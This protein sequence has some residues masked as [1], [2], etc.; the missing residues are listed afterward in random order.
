[1]LGTPASPY[2]QRWSDGRHSWRHVAEGGF[3]ASRFEITTIPEATARA[4]TIRHHYAASFPAARFTYGLVT[5][6]ETLRIDGTM[7][8]GKALVGVAV[9]SVPMHA[10]VLTNVFPDLEPFTESLELGRFVLTDTPANAESWFLGRL[11]RRAASDGI[12]G[13]VSFADPLPRHRTVTDIDD[14]GQVATRLEQVTPGHCGVIYQAANA[15]SLGR[16]T[17][18]TLTYVPRAG[19]V[20]S[21]RTLSKIRGQER[22]SDAA[23]RHLVDLGATPRGPRADPS[24]WLRD[25]L[26]EIG[27]RS[28][29]HPGNYR[30]AWT[31][32][33]GAARRRD[34]VLLP[35]TPYPKPETG[36]VRV[37]AR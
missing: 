33:P 29:R 28:V 11:F 7:I 30:Y 1:M 20:L 18:R 25:A 6:D 26:D 17:A 37:G 24:A 3:D 14:A 13:I 34:R 8:D 31:I 35:R 15:L 19:L 32:G 16:S 23:E 12:R 36:R 27:A 9:L 10:R 4:F 21:A 22:G 5:D 2:C